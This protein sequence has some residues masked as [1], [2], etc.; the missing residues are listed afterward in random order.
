MAKQVIKKTIKRGEVWS[1]D[2]FISL[3]S[4]IEKQTSVIQ[5]GTGKMDTLVKFKK[6][7]NITI[8]IF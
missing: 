8:E 6:T 2:E 3:Y 5:E 4:N 1:P 7:I